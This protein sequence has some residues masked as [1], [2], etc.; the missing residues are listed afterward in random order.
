MADMNPWH[1]QRNS[2]A[3]CFCGL[4]W[5]FGANILWVEDRRKISQPSRSCNSSFETRWGLTRWGPCFIERSFSRSA[6]VG[7]DGIN[8]LLQG[9]SSGQNEWDQ[10]VSSNCWFSPVG[11]Q[12]K[13]FLSHKIGFNMNGRPQSCDDAIS[14]FFHSVRA[15]DLFSCYSAQKIW[16]CDLLKLVG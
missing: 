15:W 11:G 10:R 3:V 7:E 6:W 12:S 13:V 2:L 5:R 9:R 4:D 1:P 8:K 16:G 14:K